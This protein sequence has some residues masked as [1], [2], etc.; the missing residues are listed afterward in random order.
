M[1]RTRS[2][3]IANI[4]RVSI[5]LLILLFLLPHAQAGSNGPNAS[6]RVL[7]RMKSPSDATTSAKD[8]RARQ[9]T[10]NRLREANSLNMDSLKQHLL[11][12]EASVSRKNLLQNRLN[13]HGLWI[14]DS[15]ALTATP[16]EIALL[17]AH[18]DVIEILSNS[19]L[20]IPP[21]TVAATNGGTSTPWNL[22]AINLYTIRSMGIG[23]GTG[24]RIGQLDTGINPSIP[25][26]QGKLAAWSEFDSNGNPVASQPHESS[27]IGHGTTVA[28]VMVG[29]TLGIAPG[30]TILSSLVLPD[31]QGTLEQVLSGL[32]WV[33]DPDNNPATNNGADVV[34]MSWG[35]AG[36]CA[37]LWQAISNMLAAGVLPVAA[38]GNGGPGDTLAPGNALEAVG[39]GAVD[40]NQQVALF[41]GG[42]Q[43]C[44]ESGYCFTKPDITAPGV[45]VPG[46]DG[47]GNYQELSGT[48]LAAPHVTGIAALLKQ[49]NP[50]L[51]GADLR[52][53]L[54]NEAQQLGTPGQQDDRYGWGMLDPLPS[55]QMSLSYKSRVGAPD[56]VCEFDTPPS[57]QYVTVFSDGNGNLLQ[58][59]TQVVN[60][61]NNASKTIQ[62]LG[63]ADVDGDGYGDLVTVETTQSGGLYFINYVVY[64]S[65]NGKGFSNVGSTW[66]SVV[67]SSPQPYVFIGLADVNG[68]KRAD[69]VLAV[70][71]YTQFGYCLHVLPMISDGQSFAPV[72]NT[73]W[74]NVYCSSYTQSTFFLADVNG[75]GKADL[76]ERTQIPDPY[77]RYPAD[78]Y[79]GLST[80]SIFTYMRDWTTLNPVGVSGTPTH[81]GFADVNGDGRADLI[82]SAAGWITG[83]TSIYVCSAGSFNQFMP[84]VQWAVISTPAAMALGDVN[85]DGLA[86]LITATYSPSSGTY[87]FNVLLANKIRQTFSPV[88]AQSG[89]S[90]SGAQCPGVF[91]L[92]TVSDVGFGIW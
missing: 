20:S 61:N 69:L 30:A 26:L 7:V 21:V 56:L 88:Q 81:V 45:N 83:T 3:K 9:Q 59:E 33:L 53:F 34:N 43:S 70:K 77:N 80:G 13:M 60:L 38:I 4:G 19:T 76:I 39:V 65:V 86:D 66:F 25:D 22:N 72:S 10:F 92:M 67:S 2:E 57:N 82:V 62:T 54:L 73:Y 29:N 78:Y 18:P 87:N 64:P 16:D 6:A 28:T 40:S 42:G 36:A 15:I 23:D 85:K 41:S 75:D 35:I 71:E 37:P 50:A 49:T 11:Q 90:L 14:A 32:Q 63:I 8:V 68:D 51:T 1:S 84:P 5:I 47:Q 91:R 27:D 79:V 44:T 46:F 89:C 48:S 58:N 52:A 31:G 55:W 74:A 17:Q 12:H 24:V